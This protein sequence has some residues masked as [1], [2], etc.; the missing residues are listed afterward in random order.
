VD[1]DR[2]QQVLWN[3]IRNAL[4]ATRG[5][6]KIHLELKLSTKKG[7][8]GVKINV[9]DDGVG[10]PVEDQEQIFEPFFTR[11]ARGSG[12]GLAMVQ[13]TIRAHGGDV[14]VKSNEGKGSVFTVW[15]PAGQKNLS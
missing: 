8:A 6:G 14:T 1:R 2:M 11:K 15:L 5:R 13:S 3:L 10:I 4:E 12:L 9:A 7:R